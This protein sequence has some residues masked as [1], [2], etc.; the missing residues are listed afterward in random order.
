MGTLKRFLWS[1]LAVV[2]GGML[3][4]SEN[5]YGQY[6]IAPIN[7][8]IYKFEDV[9]SV[10][11][12]VGGRYI[13]ADLEDAIKELDKEL[14]AKQKKFLRDSAQF[15][16]LHFELGMWIRN[17]WGLW[18]HSRLQKYF[19]K[20]GSWDADDMS[21]IIIDEYL[22]YLQGKPYKTKLEEDPVAMPR[23]VDYHFNDS[24]IER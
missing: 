9:H 17:N 16:D 22:N 20:H 18:G 4:H 2:A 7:G 19:L 23:N 12:K 10:V 5:L 24:F 13:P 6:R 15:V 11:A 21:S 8:V 3:F 14:D 1:L